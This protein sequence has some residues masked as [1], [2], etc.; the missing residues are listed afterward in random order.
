ML[1]HYEILGVTQTAENDEIKKAY[2]AM[3]KKHHPDLNGEGSG[4]LFAAVNEAY[5]TLS[6]PDSRAAYDSLVFGNMPSESNTEPQEEYEEYESNGSSSS[7]GYSSG[8][9]S[10]SRDSG[11]H[12]DG[13]PQTEV[14][15]HAY[16]WYGKDYSAIQPK[17][18]QPFPYRATSWS[19]NLVYVVLTLLTTLLFALIVAADG[20]IFLA[21]AAIAVEAFVL[22]LWWGKREDGNPLFFHIVNGLVSGG[23]VY[24]LFANVDGVQSVVWTGIFFGL[25][26]ATRVFAGVQS[27]KYGHK[28]LSEVSGVHMYHKLPRKDMLEYFSWGEAGNLDDAVDKF[29]AENVNRGSVGEKYTAEL[30]NHFG[31]IP[32]VKV[33]HGLRFPG[34]KNADVDHVIVRGNKAIFIDSKQWSRGQY[35]WKNDGTIKQLLAGKAYTRNSNFHNAI[36][37]YERILPART[38]I[39]A[40]MMLHGTDISVDSKA[41]MYGKIYMANTVD[42]IGFIGQVLSEDVDGLIDAP[43]LNSFVNSLKT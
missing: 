39:H 34:S 36:D 18:T 32:G 4:A 40:V 35:S 22:K 37:G 5:S 9:N 33:L 28:A 13:I 6:K 41:S 15:W 19:L 29:G 26:A 21:L 27:I 42:A 20:S 30:L 38:E 3:S 24:W 7:N 2:R 43:I 12:Y 11:Y 31:Q 17:V 8:R 14:D 16:S 10:S 23:M 25:L 1:N